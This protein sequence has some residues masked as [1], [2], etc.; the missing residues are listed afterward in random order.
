M[1]KRRRIRVWMVP[2]MRGGDGLL[3]LGVCFAVGSLAGTLLVSRFWSG[4]EASV[5]QY[6]DTWVLGLEAQRQ[7]YA[8]LTDL[9][10]HLRFPGAVLL[11]GFVPIGVGAI[12]LL[13]LARGVLISF[14]VSAFFKLYAWR[15]MA[16]ALLLYGPAELAGLLLQFVV[17]VQALRMARERAFAT[18]TPRRRKQTPSLRPGLLWG[19]G[20]L[21]ISLLQSALTPWTMGLIARLLSA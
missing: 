20:M 2:N 14:T 6:L 8:W 17:G 16:A 13:F 7:P 4:G 10:H 3:W 11:C 1:A 12:P 18:V 5:S 15:G 9:V 19:V 21:G